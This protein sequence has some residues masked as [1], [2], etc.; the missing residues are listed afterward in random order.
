MTVYCDLSIAVISVCFSSGE[1]EGWG[2]EGEWVRGRE[3]ER[4][5]EGGREGERE[6]KGENSWFPL[7][8]P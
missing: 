2:R 5:Q 8:D 4:W 6:V 7:P 1:E 3:R